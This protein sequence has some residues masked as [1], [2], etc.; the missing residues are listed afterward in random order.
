MTAE[1]NTACE[2]V[3]QQARTAQA[4]RAVAARSLADDA[5]I[6]YNAAISASADA[7]AAAGLDPAND[8]LASAA[9]IAVDVR[10]EKHC[11]WECLDAHAT[12][13]EGLI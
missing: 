5:L 11:I 6:I 12:H 8:T 4:A 3:S 7:T 2:T 9:N 10:T 13:L 1:Q